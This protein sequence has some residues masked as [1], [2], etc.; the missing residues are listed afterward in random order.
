MRV[1]IP[2]PRDPSQLPETPAGKV[3]RAVARQVG[4]P[5]EA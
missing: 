1:E 3:F 5:Q 4:V 2:V